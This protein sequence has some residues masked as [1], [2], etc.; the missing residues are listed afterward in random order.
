M[1]RIRRRPRSRGQALAEFALTLPIFLILV[2]GM[3]DVGRAVYTYNTLTNAAREGARFAIVNQDETSIA[4]RTRQIAVG[5]GV[6][7]TD[8]NLVAFYKKGPAEDV[9]T[10]AACDGSTASPIT[11]GCVVVVKPRTTWQAITPLIGGLIGPITMQARSELPIEFV[12]PDATNAAI[13]T[14]ASCPKQL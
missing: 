3:L 2:F 12:C 10:N 5:V 14:A 7:M 1:S 11:V 4:D 6:D 9:E 8:P 13:A